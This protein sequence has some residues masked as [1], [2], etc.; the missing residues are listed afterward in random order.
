MLTAMPPSS[1]WQRMKRSPKGGGR[2]ESSTIVKLK[3]RT[4]HSAVARGSDDFRWMWLMRYGIRPLVQRSS[5]HALPAP[6]KHRRPA[7]SGPAAGARWSLSGHQTI[8]APEWLA[9]AVAQNE[10]ATGRYV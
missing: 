4:Y 3:A 8:F 9:P 6:A 2:T 10:D 7:G 5:A 1:L